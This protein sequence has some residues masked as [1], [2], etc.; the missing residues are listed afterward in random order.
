MPC[1]VRGSYCPGP[2]QL[3]HPV[4]TDTLSVADLLCRFYVVVN[5]KHQLESTHDTFVEVENSQN[6]SCDRP[7]ET[8]T[9]QLSVAAICQ[10]VSRPQGFLISKDMDGRGR[11]LGRF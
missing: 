8:C 3:T 10:H 2:A 9:Q 11:H 7:L 5:C 4:R 1:C 6:A